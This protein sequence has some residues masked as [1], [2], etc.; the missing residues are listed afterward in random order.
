V[1]ALSLIKDKEK[2]DVP[3][4]ERT[5]ISHDTFVLKFRLPQE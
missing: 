5:Q 4:M 2:L 3:L 1:T